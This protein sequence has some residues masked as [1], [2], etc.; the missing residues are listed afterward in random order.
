MKNRFALVC[1]KSAFQEW[2]QGWS[3]PASLLSF[4][5]P[6]PD[7]PPTSFND[8]EMT[9][10]SSWLK[11]NFLPAA[12]GCCGV[13][14]IGHW[15][16]WKAIDMKKIQGYFEVSRANFKLIHAFY[17]RFVFGT[18]LSSMPELLSWLSADWPF[19]S[20]VGRC[21][22][23]LFSTT[24]SLTVSLLI[25]KPTEMK[26]LAYLIQ[27]YSQTWCGSV[28]PEFV[29]PWVSPQLSGHLYEAVAIT[30]E[31]AWTAS[32]YNLPPV[33]SGHL[34]RNYLN[35]SK[36]YPSRKIWSIFFFRNQCQ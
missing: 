21:F 1:S 8:S 7:V 26:M 24:Q 4:N 31:W 28:S 17:S 9:P 5:P 27:N 32:L 36:N 30:F 34:R 35:K 2:F 6:P 22:S 20:C 23:V 13:Q 10:A 29:F 33:L 16:W 15:E 25:L 3:V 12:L 18:V 19:T 14:R 11:Q